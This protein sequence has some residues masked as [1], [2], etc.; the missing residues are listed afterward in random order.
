MRTR[1]ITTALSI[2]LVAAFQSRAQDLSSKLGE[3]RSSYNSGSLDDARFALEQALQQIDQAVGR[4]IL[5]ILPTDL[6][7]MNFIEG[8]DNVVGTNLGF[9]G[10]FVDRN[11]GQGEKNAGIDIIGDSPLM[12]GLNAMLALPAIMT[13]GDQ[14]Q[15]RIKVDG[16]KSLLQ[17]ESGSEGITSYSV[18]I[19]ANHTLITLNVQGYSESEV[20]SMANMIPVSQ[21]VKLAR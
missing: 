7:G 20:I 17:K 9:A 6:M 18:Q 10:L 14:D 19:P 3:A 11:Y 5:K 21:I 2:I 12:A 4:E 16:Y 15:K 8:E 1:I 13:Q